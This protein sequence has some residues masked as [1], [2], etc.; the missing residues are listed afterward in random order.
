[1]AVVVEEAEVLEAEGG[2]VLQV[3][4]R[5]MMNTMSMMDMVMIDIVIIIIQWEVVVVEGVVQMEDLVED[6]KIGIKF[7]CSI[8]RRSV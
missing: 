3:V 4:V 6:A 2:E 1:M 7:I 5:M 8:G